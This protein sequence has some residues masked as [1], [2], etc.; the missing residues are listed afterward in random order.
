M[1]GMIA[2]ETERMEIHFLSDIFVAV[3]VVVS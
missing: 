3:T 1:V 2:I